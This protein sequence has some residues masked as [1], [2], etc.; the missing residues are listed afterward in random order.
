[1]NI[2]KEEKE[3]IDTVDMWVVSW[4]CRYGEFSNDTKMCFQSFFTYEDAYKLKNALEDAHRLIGN[5]SG[6]RVEIEKR[7]NGI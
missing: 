4:K 3:Q 5:T 1:M 7:S 6:T 2:F